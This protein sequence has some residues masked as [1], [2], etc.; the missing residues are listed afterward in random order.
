MCVDEIEQH[1]VVLEADLL[2]LVSH[3]NFRANIGE[4]SSIIDFDDFLKKSFEHFIYLVLFSVVLLL[5]HN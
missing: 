5:Y 3:V 2:F 1:F 4:V